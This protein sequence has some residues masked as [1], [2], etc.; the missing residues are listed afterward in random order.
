MKKCGVPAEQYDNALGCVEKKVSVLYKQK[1]CEV[2]IGR[3]NT[4]ILK[5]LKFTMN[6]QFV[7]G[8]YAM[9]M[10]LTSYS[11]K[12]ED[13]MSELMKKASMEKVLNVKCFVLVIH[14]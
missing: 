8:A 5:L 14:F 10:Y 11:C 13:A 7:A 6:L 12:P 4:V 9:L 3:Y 2:N 1:P